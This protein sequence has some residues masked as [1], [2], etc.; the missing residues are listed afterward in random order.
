MVL[1]KEEDEKPKKGIALQAN[2]D[3][4]SEEMARLGLLVIVSSLYSSALLPFQECS[5][6][7]D[8]LCV[9]WEEIAE[10]FEK[11]RYMR[12]IVPLENYKY[13]DVI[14]SKITGKID[15]VKDLWRVGVYAQVG[16][17]GYGKVYRGT[18]ADGTVVAIKH[19]QEG[20]GLEA[21]IKDLL[22]FVEHRHHLET[23]AHV[24]LN[25]SGESLVVVPFS[26][27]IGAYGERIARFLGEVL[28][29]EFM[30]KGQMPDGANLL[31][32]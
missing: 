7:Q 20:Y 29:F 25:Y 32:Y 15:G 26:L 24:L 22:P 19:A 3:E 18:L 23:T 9:W 8:L 28:G 13:G 21:A 12:I 2:K 31:A 17:G 4:E 6:F 10:M 11:K 16:Q 27:Q 30:K 5:V 1:T 14:V